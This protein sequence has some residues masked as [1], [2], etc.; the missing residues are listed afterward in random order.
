MRSAW[1]EVGDAVV[2]V[3]TRTGGLWAGLEAGMEAST[4]SLAEGEARAYR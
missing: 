4:G 2:K 1:L 3:V